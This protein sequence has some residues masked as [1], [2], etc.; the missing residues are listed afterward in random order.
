MKALLYRS[1]PTFEETWME[2]LRDP[3]CYRMAIED[4]DL[5]T[6]PMS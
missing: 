5:A 1:I 3:G 4:D 6:V 2:Y